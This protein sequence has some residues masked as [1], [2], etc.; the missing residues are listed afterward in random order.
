[1]ASQL[2]LV[3]PR[4]TTVQLSDGNGRRD[5]AGPQ[6]VVLQKKRQGRDALQIRF[7]SDGR[8]SL[9]AI[10]GADRARVVCMLESTGGMFTTIK[11]RERPKKSKPGN[12]PRNYKVK[13]TGI[14]L[15]MAR[16]SLRLAIKPR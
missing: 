2:N 1:M 6:N 7:R 14:G 10:R 12:G 15:L 9:V 11:V 8:L 5:I 3:V 4:N 16:G 13:K